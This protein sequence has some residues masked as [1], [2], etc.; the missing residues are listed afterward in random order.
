M[1]RTAVMNEMPIND[2]GGMKSGNS[3]GKYQRLSLIG[4]GGCGRVYRAFDP[5]LERYVALK[6]LNRNLSNLPEYKELFFREVKLQAQLNLPGMVRVF[7]YGETGGHLFYTMELIDG[8]TIDV[9][10]RRKNLSV[11]ARLKL[12][13]E[14]ASTVAALHERDIIH[15]DIKPRNI[16]IDEHG[17][18]RLL[19]LGVA[20]SVRESD[21]FVGRFGV[22]G[23]PGY[24]APE[25]FTCP[26]AAITTA[27]DVYA[28]GILAYEVLSGELPFD[29]DFLSLQ[30][31]GEVISLEAPKPLKSDN[32]A[33]IPREVEKIIK[34][35]MCIAPSARPEAEE[36]ARVMTHVRHRNGR[37][38][39]PFTKYAAIF[40]GSAIAATIVYVTINKEPNKGSLHNGVGVSQVQSNVSQPRPA[41]IKSRQNEVRPQPAVSNKSEHQ[42]SVSVLPE[43]T[44]KPKVLKPVK[45]PAKNGPFYMNSAPPGLK[46]LWNDARIE[47]SSGT[48]GALVFDLPAK[49]ILKVKKGSKVI[50]EMDSR[51]QRQGCIYRTKGEFIYL[52]LSDLNGKNVKTYI[53]RAK[54][55]SADV[56]QP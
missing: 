5:D 19:D 21:M 25:M 47:I 41:E 44:A 9:Y 56:F 10:C 20:A 26:D 43:M 32:Q 17:K 8:V 40:C 46:Y 24:L 31:I 49:V 28:L 29:I 54:S 33:T 7:E 38:I 52:E 53:W 16:M 14:V 45:L 12:L 1:I 2:A 18:V 34:Q 27:V 6:V 42:T 50:F 3:L 4:Q 30:E 39:R 13:G 48:K 11:Q 55:G 23:S 36:F 37:G 35:A 15:R 22:S 51:F